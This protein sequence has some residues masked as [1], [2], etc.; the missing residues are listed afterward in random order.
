MAVHAS[1][2]TQTEPLRERR[3]THS[4][5]SSP[6]WGRRHSLHKHTGAGRT[7]SA[8]QIPRGAQWEVVTPRR[9]RRRAPAPRQQM[10]RPSSLMEVISSAKLSAATI[11]GVPPVGAAGAASDILRDVSV[12]AEKPVA[13]TAHVKSPTGC[14]R[15]AGRRWCTIPAGRTAGY[16]R[17]R[18]CSACA[19]CVS[20]TAAVRPRGTDER[21]ARPISSRG[22]THRTGGARC[23]QDCDTTVLRAAT[24]RPCLVQA[25][26][27]Y[28]RAASAPVHA[29][30]ATVPSAAASWR[31]TRRCV[32]LPAY[33]GAGGR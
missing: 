10:R 21:P 13:R 14:S 12:P 26:P 29:L 31:T 24:R 9:G 28:P 2:S 33:A 17:Q 3:E 25:S 20:F 8:R 6:S 1:G 30:V 32:A 23:S 15:R 11:L 22:D 4:W 27:R 16:R 7:W 19:V 5:R 18:T